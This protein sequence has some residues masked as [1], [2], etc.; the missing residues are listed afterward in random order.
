[1]RRT[2]H[3]VVSPQETPVAFVWQLATG[4]GY[5]LSYMYMPF[6][7]TL[8]EGFLHAGRWNINQQHISS[9]DLVKRKL[10]EA[11]PRS[12][13]M[14]VWV[15]H[16][17]SELVDFLALQKR[18][19]HTVFVNLEPE[20]NCVQAEQK[21][22]LSEIWTYTWKNIDNC[23]PAHDAF[24]QRYVPSGFLQHSPNTNHQATH[25]QA[26]FL[27]QPA[28]RKSCYD[29]IQH[30]FGNA[31]EATT[32]VWDDA[33]FQKYITLHSI[34]VH[35]PKGCEVEAPVT[36]AR[37]SSLLSS[38][39][40]VISMHA[41]PKDE[42]EFRGLVTFVPLEKLYEAYVNISSLTAEERRRKASDIRTAYAKKFT[43]STIFQR[44]GVYNLLD[45]LATG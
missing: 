4:Y 27:G 40:F 35:L 1:M 38:E 36:A 37:M 39:A 42:A 22:G 43:P 23:M 16:P 12:G 17:A 45:K 6:T 26:S 31:L 14:F 21:A 30:Q 33:A 5:D 9:G 20:S 28:F 19:V 8:V 7:N 32:D 13:D 10:E 41:Y 2:R 25:L 29:M 3:G 18:G 11:A 34:F 24:V 44:A 15:G